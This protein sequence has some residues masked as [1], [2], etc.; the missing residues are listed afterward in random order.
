M[1]LLACTDGRYEVRFN[2]T[3]PSIPVLIRLQLILIG[4]G[5]PDPAIGQPI[6]RT[7]TLPPIVIQPNKESAEEFPN[8][9]EGGV[10]PTS[11]L[12]SARGYSQ[13]IKEIQRAG[14]RPGHFLLVKRIGT[15]RIGNGVQYQQVG[16]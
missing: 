15:A 8:N 6:P 10:Y 13:V 16:P 1:R 3:A 7:L 14:E 2:I 11:Y 4:Q 5:R 9:L 12:V